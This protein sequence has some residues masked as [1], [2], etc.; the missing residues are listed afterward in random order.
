MKLLSFMCISLIL[1][2][3]AKAENKSPIDG[4]QI[5]A[6]QNYEKEMSLDMCRSL[7]HR[8][9]SDS[10]ACVYCAHGL[11]YD[12]ESLKCM[13]TPDVIGK[14]FGEDHYHASTKECMYCGKEYIFDE[15]IRECMPV[16]KPPQEREKKGE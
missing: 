9:D 11:H 15:D 4:K 2:T 14:C 6:E 7:N 12:L 13:G 3:L 10:H 8:F 16:G 1:G 5:D